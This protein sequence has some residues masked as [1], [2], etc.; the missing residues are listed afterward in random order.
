MENTIE[1]NTSSD[2]FLPFDPIVVV[3]DVMKHWLTI[4]L[5]A[6]AVGVGSYI[7]TD[8]EYAP[9]YQCKATFVVNGEP[10]YVVEFRAGDTTLTEPVVPHVPGMIGRWEPYTL[11]DEDITVHA[12]YTPDGA[13]N[14]PDMPDMPGEETSAPTPD[15][16]GEDGTEGGDSTQSGGCKSVLDV[17]FVA[18]LLTAAVG[19][20]KKKE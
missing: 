4:V 7:M 9:R 6:L 14:V 10:L 8:M 20:V 11:G 5:V 19:L 18:L 2:S 12:V 1:M 3:R 16:E 13:S 17:G 15:T